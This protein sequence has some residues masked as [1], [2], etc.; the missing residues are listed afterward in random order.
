MVRDASALVA[1]SRQD[2][3]LLI[4]LL[5]NSEALAQWKTTKRLAEEYW[6]I[7]EINVDFAEEIAE[8]VS[9]QEYLVRELL[10]RNDE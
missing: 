2:S 5:H 8:L 9:E 6:L 10:K 4:S 1:V 3:D 7:R